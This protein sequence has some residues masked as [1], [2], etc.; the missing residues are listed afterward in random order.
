MAQAPSVLGEQFRHINDAAA[1]PPAE[2]L[3]T[4]LA[5]RGDLQ[6]DVP[7]ATVARLLLAGPCEGSHIIAAAADRESA[8]TRT[9]RAITL[10]MSGLADGTGTWRPSSAAMT[11]RYRAAL[12]SMSRT[13]SMA[14]PRVASRT[15]R[16]SPAG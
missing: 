13:R 10:L 3:L 9:F 7:V 6:P 16:V 12:S 14:R 5:E 15:S 1:R 2:R 11:C 8:L 4:V